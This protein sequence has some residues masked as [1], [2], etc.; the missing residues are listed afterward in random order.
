[1]VG[2]IL[3]AG[4]GTR[5]RPFTFFLPKPLLPYPRRSLVRRQ[6]SFLQELGCKRI[7]VTKGYKGS[8]LEFF[9]KRYDFIKTINVSN[10]GNAYF[11][12][13]LIT[14]GCREKVVVITSDNFINLDTK[15][16]LSNVVNSSNS[17]VVC[18]PGYL[19][20]EGDVAVLESQKILE[21]RRSES[22]YGKHL[23]SGLQVIN[24]LDLEEMKFDSN[25]NFYNVWEHLIKQGKLSLAFF[26]SVDWCAIDRPKD[27]VHAFTSRFNVYPKN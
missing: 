14:Q 15:K 9:L 2:V 17:F 21:I 11:L 24:L 10:K 8:V 27:L 12:F 22:P 19:A 23:L 5:L 3:G 16:F 4:K 18:V 25:L 13:E 20:R 26:D 6:I 1:M 7:F